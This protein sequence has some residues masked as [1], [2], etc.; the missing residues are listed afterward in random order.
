MYEASL[1]SNN[2]V[3]IYTEFYSK[4]KDSVHYEESVSGSKLIVYNASKNLHF[5]KD[6]KNQVIYCKGLILNKKYF[7][8]DSI[9]IFDWKLEKD[10]LS[11]LGIKCQIATLKFRGRNYTAYYTNEIK[12]SDG[13]WKFNGLPGLIL[14]VFSDDGLYDFEAVSLTKNISYQIDYK[15]LIDDYKNNRTEIT[16]DEYKIDKNQK[17]KELYLKQ[18]SEFSETGGSFSKYTEIEVFFEYPTD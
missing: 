6:F 3:S 14:K 12:A 4:V 16:F 11:V 8:I 18:K 17:L 5:I 1:V 15:K 2:E 9:D 7:V 10:T 13:P